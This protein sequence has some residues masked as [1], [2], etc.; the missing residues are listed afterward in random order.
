MQAMFFDKLELLRG[1]SKSLQISVG[2]WQDQMEGKEILNIVLSQDLFKVKNNK[3]DVIEGKEK[4]NCIIKD[5]LKEKNR[6]NKFPQELLEI[7]EKAM[8]KI[9]GMGKTNFNHIK[10][11]Q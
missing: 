10:S 6:A 8:Q 7:M 3:N 11:I 1:D 9:K 5:L 4:S 2:K